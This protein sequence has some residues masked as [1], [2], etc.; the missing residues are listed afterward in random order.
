MRAALASLDG[1]GSG[2]AL[3]VREE[4]TAALAIAGDRQAPQ[5]ATDHDRLR[6]R[7]VSHQRQALEQLRIRGEI[8]DEA[9]HRVEEEIDWAELDAAPAGSFQP[10]TT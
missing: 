3:A 10:L 2:V 7:A 8:G 9:Y 4:Y 1:D 6:L 5:A